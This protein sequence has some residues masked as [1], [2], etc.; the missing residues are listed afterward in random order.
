MYLLVV[1]FYNLL[2]FCGVH[3]NFFFISNFIDL[4]PLSFFSDEFSERLFNFAYLFEPTL[5]VIFAI[6][7]FNSILFTSPLIFMILSFYY[8]WIFCCCSSS[9]FSS[10]FRCKV[11]LLICDFSC[12]LKQDCIAINFPPIIAFSTSHRFWIVMFVCR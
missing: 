4:S 10:G 8:L 12:L 11:M 6:V 2:Y 3:C 9:S 1:V 5:S 7:F